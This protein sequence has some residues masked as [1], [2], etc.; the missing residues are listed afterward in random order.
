M[1][2]PCHFETKSTIQSWSFDVVPEDG[3]TQLGASAPGTHRPTGASWVPHNA[4]GAAVKQVHITRHRCILHSLDEKKH[5]LEHSNT[6][7][8]WATIDACCFNQL[9]QVE[10]A[11]MLNFM[12]GRDAAHIRAVSTVSTAQFSTRRDHIQFIHMQ[13]AFGSEANNWNT[14]RKLFFLKKTRR[15]GGELRK[16]HFFGGQKNWKW[17]RH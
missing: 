4:T 8:R 13:C 12:R 16:R 1:Q 15:R 11:M 9:Y 10:G 2:N 17:V 6:K 7:I 14:R 3:D 5:Q